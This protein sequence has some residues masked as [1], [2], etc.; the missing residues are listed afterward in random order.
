MHSGF[1]GYWKHARRQA[2][3]EARDVCGPWGHHGHHGHGHHGQHGEDEGYEA[4]HGD[5]HGGGVL[6]GVRRPLRFMAHKLELDETQIQILAHI[7]DD[8]KTERAQAAVD[9]R[10]SLG[11]LAASL[12]GDAFGA[13]KANE[14]L[15]LRVK[16]A[17]RLRAAVYD[18][19]ERTFAML[20][21]EQRSKLS[22]M[23]RSGVL[24]I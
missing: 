19:L 9:E 23:L 17:E 20:R 10:R 11:A 5:R 2:W 14:G 22:Y 24:T 1:F 3:R 16:S 7:L 13:D 8:L 21:P 4:S 15:A 18:A 6:F 12:E